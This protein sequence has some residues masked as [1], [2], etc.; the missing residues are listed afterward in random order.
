MVSPNKQAA[1][2]VGSNAKAEQV[3][4]TPDLSQTA[5]ISL[6]R[7]LTSKNILALQR[8]V[9]NQAV[10]RILRQADAKPK[11]PTK[12]PVN[13]PPIQKTASAAAIQRAIG[14]EIEV[15]VPVDQ[16]SVA[17]ETSIR[18]AAGDDPDAIP[19]M[20]PLG[21]MGL[22]KR[23]V[24]YT[25]NNGPKATNG[26]FRAEVDHDPRV[27]TEKDPAFP[28]RDMNNSALLEIVTE[29][30]DDK[31][32]FD[33]AMN[34]V[35]A[36]IADVNTRTNNLTTHAHDPYGSGHNIGPIDYPDLDPMPR[37]PNHNWKGSIQVNIGID[38][39][40]YASLAKWYAKSTYAD[41]SKA[42]KHNKGDFKKAKDNILKAVDIG[43]SV[44]ETLSKPMD[45]AQRT[46]MGNLRGLR[47]WITHMALYMIGGKGGLPEGST[48]KNI[49]PILMKSP[50]EIAI[51]YSMTPDELAYYQDN[52]KRQAIVVLL[53]AKTG[54]RDLDPT[55]PL[56][57][58]IVEG[59]PNQGTLEDLS[60][61]ENVTLFAGAPIPGEQ[62]VGPSRTDEGAD[63]T[64]DTSTGGRGGAVVEFRNLPG[65]HE[66]PAAWRQL[67]YDFLRQAENR[68]KRGGSKP[69]KLSKL[70][71]D[72]WD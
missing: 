36:F 8:L 50:N 66:G 64:T 29:P 40:E 26:N 62:Q 27:N 5:P 13:R 63:Q 34:D 35:D 24:E 15:S 17:E 1:E 4:E 65:F 58:S 7:G 16:L 19:K 38:M 3:P 30:K 22:R 32:A 20:P 25:R 46:A 60:D 37:Q 44:T 43:R 23:K 39:R 61:D 12:Q 41:P 57:G 18:D 72:D 71:S 47:G 53:I 9:G 54:R 68:N 2:P 31:A 28:Y 59:T 51:E 55:D 70:Q 52:T 6:E 11:S 45:K 56:G 49:T 10:M 42:E 67:G 69:D 21:V 14:L 48:A 33:D